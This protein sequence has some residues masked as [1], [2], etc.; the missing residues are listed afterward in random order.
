MPSARASATSGTSGFRE[1]WT[2]YAALTRSLLVEVSSRDPWL[3]TTIAMEVP[4]AEGS[5]AQNR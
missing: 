4:A 3:G 1:Y 2:S 5:E